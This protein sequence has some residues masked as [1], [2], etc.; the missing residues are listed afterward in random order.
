MLVFG[1]AGQ[2]GYITLRV[3]QLPLPSRFR[4]VVGSQ[5]DSLSRKPLRNIPP[6]ET[7]SAN[8]LGSF[9]L[10]LQVRY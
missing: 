1:L 4:R 9:L 8:T 6:A 10:D 3:M 7:F 5:G 2:Y